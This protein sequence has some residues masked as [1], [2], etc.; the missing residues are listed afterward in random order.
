M[1]KRCEV[2][3][4]R[5]LEGVSTE[6]VETVGGERQSKQSSAVSEQLLQAVCPQGYLTIGPFSRSL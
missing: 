6:L 3:L 5:S 4:T 2:F 1:L